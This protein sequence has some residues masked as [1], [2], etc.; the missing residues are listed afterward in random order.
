VIDQIE[1]PP[2]KAEKICGAVT[3]FEVGVTLLEKSCKTLEGVGPPVTRYAKQLRTALSGVQAISR[4][5]QFLRDHLGED[6]QNT[7]PE[8]D[9]ET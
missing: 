5:L 9:V 4:K 7:Q 2:A 3:D 8:N 6:P 1:A